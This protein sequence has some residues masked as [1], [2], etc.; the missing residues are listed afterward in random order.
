MIKLE[1]VQTFMTAK[2]T[3][4]WTSE[5]KRFLEAGE[6]PLVYSGSYEFSADVQKRQA[7]HCHY[8]ALCEIRVFPCVPTSVQDIEFLYVIRHSFLWPLPKDT[9]AEGKGDK[10][11]WLRVGKS[12]SSSLIVCGSLTIGF[13]WGGKQFP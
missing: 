11:W 12:Y 6:S 1:G 10:N 4:G 7:A 13:A 5:L 2:Q 9:G 3:Q 8:G